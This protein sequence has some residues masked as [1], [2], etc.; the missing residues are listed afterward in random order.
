MQ[1][2]VILVAACEAM[3]RIATGLDY[4]HRKIAEI[5]GIRTPGGK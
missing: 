5:C 1:P 4:R 3:E 2:V